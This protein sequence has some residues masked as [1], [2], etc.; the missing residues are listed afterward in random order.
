NHE[1]RFA[2]CLPPEPRTRNI[3]VDNLSRVLITSVNY[4]SSMSDFT[5]LAYEDIE[6]SRRPS[7][8]EA[9]VPVVAVGVALGVGSGY[10]GLAPHGP[11]LW[12]IV[13]T[14]LFA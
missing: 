8:A 11:L 9:L 13:F 2:Q 14:G 12:T 10:L 6:P 5:P 7:L 1:C 4:P 3:P